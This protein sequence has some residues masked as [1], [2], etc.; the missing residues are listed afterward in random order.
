VIYTIRKFFRKKKKSL[1][2]D[3]L[4]N[5]L[6][7]EHQKLFDVVT[8]MSE[9]IENKDIKTIQKLITIFTKE[10]ELHLLYEDTNLYEHLYLRYHYFNEISKEIER[11][12]NEMKDIAKAVE[13]FIQKHKNLDN[14]EEFVKDFDTVKDVLVKRVAFEEEILYEIYDNKLKP[15]EILEKL[16]QS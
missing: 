5:K 11:K 13:G 7:K 16:K 15:A 8:K 3:E 10:L 14:F 2:Q 1:Y 6:H 4:I 9:A 12:H